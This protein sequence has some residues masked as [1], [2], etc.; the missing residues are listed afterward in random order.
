MLFWLLA[1]IYYNGSLNDHKG[2]SPD[3]SSDNSSTPPPNMNPILKDEPSF[4]LPL[5]LGLFII[6]LV[7]AVI[8]ILLLLHH[9]GYLC[10]CDSEES[11]DEFEQSEE[12]F[13]EESVAIDDDEIDHQEKVRSVL[14]SSMQVTHGVAENTSTIIDVLLLDALSDRQKMAYNAMSEDQQRVWLSDERQRVVNELIRLS[15]VT[16]HNEAREGTTAPTGIHVINPAIT[17][18]PHSLQRCPADHAPE[19][20]SAVHRNTTFT[21]LATD[22]GDR[23]CST[24]TSGGLLERC[25]P[26]E[27]HCVASSSSSSTVIQLPIIMTSSNIEEQAIPADSSSRSSHEMHRVGKDSSGNSLFTIGNATISTGSENMASNG[28]EETTNPPGFNST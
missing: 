20:P 16:P 8:G 7:F 4:F 12:M 14:L 18:L 1:V 9:H 21:P 23:E 13:S 6:T 24:Y 27:A 17:S 19:I 26:I 22:P 5:L 28:E 15:A 10:C 11:F 25:R 3:S 2:N